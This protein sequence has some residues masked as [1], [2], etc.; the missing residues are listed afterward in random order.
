M[1]LAIRSAVL[2]TACVLIAGCQAP[3]P[4]TEPAAATPAQV[5]ADTSQQPARSTDAPLPAE[6]AASLAAAPTP[7]AFTNKVWR[8]SESG[9]VQKGS[10]YSFLGDGTLVIET[11]GSP[12]LYG[13]WTF[14]NG[15]LSMIEEGITY[16][17]DIVKLDARQFHIRSH[18]P[19]EP[20][21][22]VLVHAPERPLPEAP[23]AQ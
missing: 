13:R 10:T 19:G 3:T 2:A 16:P 5:T 7:A 6:S 15:A 12:P 4:P 21:E 9:A 17:T 23:V 18:N 1:T 11:P 8:V 20:V 22:I 14:E